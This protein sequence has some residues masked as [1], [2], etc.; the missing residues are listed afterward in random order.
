MI[1]SVDSIPELADST[2]DMVIVGQLPVLN[3]FDIS[4]PIQSANSSGLTIAVGRLQIG[5][6]GMGLQG[7]KNPYPLGDHA[8]RIVD[9]SPVDMTDQN[10]QV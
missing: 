2:T 10:V 9:R 3:M 7:L 4:A 5:L 6:V 1:E 8:D